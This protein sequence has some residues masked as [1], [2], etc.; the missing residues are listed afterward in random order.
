LFSS[1]INN[2]LQ[3]F[4]DSHVGNQ[5]NSLVI[6]LVGG[7]SRFQRHRQTLA[8]S[9]TL[10]LIRRPSGASSSVTVVS[11]EAGFPRHGR[12]NGFGFQELAAMRSLTFS[13]LAFF[14]Y[15]Q[16]CR[17]E[18]AHTKHLTQACTSSIQLSA[19]TNE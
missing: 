15:H 2:K 16:E 19:K 1:A 13:L 11:N 7:T 9:A 5:A 12:G 18:L 6:K 8:V 4:W 17:L 10:F 14:G 3:F